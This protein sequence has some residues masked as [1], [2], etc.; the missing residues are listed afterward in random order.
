MVPH[1]SAYGK[2]L[3]LGQGDVRLPERQMALT[4]SPPGKP[5]DPQGWGERVAEIS[6]GSEHV[7]LREVSGRVWGWGIN[8]GYEL[9]QGRVNSG[10]WV[11]PFV[12]GDDYLYAGA[13]D[14][15]SVVVLRDGS[16]LW[17]SGYG[18][19]RDDAGN[20]LQPARFGEGFILADIDNDGGRALAQDGSLWAW[21][22][23]PS[24]QMVA[25]NVTQVYGS[26][27]ILVLRRDGGLWTLNERRWV[28]PGE[29]RA[30][31]ENLYWLGA[32]FDRLPRSRNV[33]L[34]W[35]ADGTAW[36]WSETLTAMTTPE[37]LPGLGESP[38]P[39]LVGRDWVDVKA[40]GYMVAARKTDGSLWVSQDIG[41]ERHMVPVGCGFA[42]MAFAYD[43]TYGTHLLALRSDGSLLDYHGSKRDVSRDLLEREPLVLANGVVKLFGVFLLYKDGMVGQWYWRSRVRYSEEVPPNQWLH[44]INF[45][46]AWFQDRAP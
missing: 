29:S 27:P 24:I 33:Q 43:E 45:P 17:G 22:K 10:E 40:A 13:G 15:T 26:N 36:A 34:A 37:S 38:W 46:A 4:C 23:R 25:R 3:L 5:P 6:A 7:F 16:L 30:M 14:R 44:R 32:G 31:P 2:N 28:H 19:Q 41:M 11:D 1:L 8:Y 9:G 35:R 39:R 21:G 12:L 18:G 20:R 42:D